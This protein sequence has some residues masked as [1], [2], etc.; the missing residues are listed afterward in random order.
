MNHNKNRSMIFYAAV[1]MAAAALTVFTD[2]TCRVCKQFTFTAMP[3]YVLSIAVPIAVSILLYIKILMQRKMPVWYS[4]LINAIVIILFIIVVPAFYHP[5]SWTWFVSTYIL[6]AIV[7]YLQLCSFTYD[8]F[9][10]KNN[11]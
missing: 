6:T 8:I 5:L 7:F 9:F 4:R 3:L 10:R 1:N 11:S 2:I